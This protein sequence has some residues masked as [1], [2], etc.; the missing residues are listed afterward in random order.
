M[1][2]PRID[3]RPDHWEIIRTILNEHVPQYD[4]WAF[5]SRARGSAK[6]YSDLDLAVITDTSLA[7]AL[8]A[9][10]AD[11][12]S[13]SDLPYK[14]DV[15]DWATASDSFREIIQRDAVAVQKGSTSQA[16]VTPT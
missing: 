9:K 8:S 13:E 16:P 4:V 2:E 6:T 14:V 3:I 10:L 1:P 15:V 7:L 11:A 5:G 12:F